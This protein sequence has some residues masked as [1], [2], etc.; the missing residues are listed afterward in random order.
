[1]TKIVESELD[2][3]RSYGLG[4]K[5]FWGGSWLGKEW[6]KVITLVSRQIEYATLRRNS[7]NGE[8]RILLW[9]IVENFNGY[10]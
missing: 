8:M 4:G 9:I 7:D 1:M 2:K 6:S 10:G 5:D 3:K